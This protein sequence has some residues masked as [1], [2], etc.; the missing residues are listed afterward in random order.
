MKQIMTYQM[1]MAVG[2]VNS[3]RAFAL[4]LFD[5]QPEVRLQFNLCLPKDESNDAW[6]RVTIL[7]GTSA[8]VMIWDM[9]ILNWLQVYKWANLHEEFP[10]LYKPSSVLSSITQPKLRQS[11]GDLLSNSGTGDRMFSPTSNVWN[12]LL[13]WLSILLFVYSSLS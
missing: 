3:I 6:R 7:F 12:F 8:G 9:D 5:K 13:V 2:V 1:L 4:H 10:I 11:K